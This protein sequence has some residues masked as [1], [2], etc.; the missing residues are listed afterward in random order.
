VKY[1]SENQFCI[2][3]TKQMI[4][5]IWYGQQLLCVPEVPKGFFSNDHTDMLII[6]K[7]NKK[8]IAIEY[9][10][11]DLDG[12]LEQVSTNRCVRTI[13]IINRNIPVE[14][15]RNDRVFG[16]T[17][18]DYQWELMH[19]EIIKGTGSNIPMYMIW[20][21]IYESSWARIYWYAYLHNESNFSGGLK[22]SGSPTF[23]HV[24]I[25][26]IQNLQKEYN[27]KLDFLICNA[28]FDIGYSEGVAKKYYKRA[29]KEIKR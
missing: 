5:L 17:G 18:H 16:V 15:A 4:G 14:H 13:G 29:M 1:K 19:E 10:L 3:I 8:M 23:Y 6:D 9:K 24:Y 27:Y 12:L 28:M 2:D 11:K 25:R 7:L 21:T 20:T 26:A 22:N